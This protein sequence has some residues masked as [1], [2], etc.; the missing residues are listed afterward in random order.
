MEYNLIL[1]VH[2]GEKKNHTS[3]EDKIHMPWVKQLFL[4]NEKEIF[5]Y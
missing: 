4:L 1:A 5:C 3:V 2:S